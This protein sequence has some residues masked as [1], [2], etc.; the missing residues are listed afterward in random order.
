MNFLIVLGK[1]ALVVFIL[2]FLS[3][4]ATTGLDLLSNLKAKNTV[5]AYNGNTSKHRGKSAEKVHSKHN[6]KGKEEYLAEE[7]ESI[8]EKLKERRRKAKEKRKKEKLKSK[9][10]G[11]R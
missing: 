11:P 4:E 10:P 1:I 7:L 6:S 3:F 2:S 9:K 8:K 5:S